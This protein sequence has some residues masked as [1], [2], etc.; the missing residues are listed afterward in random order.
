MTPMPGVLEAAP[1]LIVESDD[2]TRTML[3]TILADAGFEVL[4]TADGLEA[5]AAIKLL[6]SQQPGVIVVSASLAVMDA[7]AFLRA[8]RQQPGP[9]APAIVLTENDPGSYTAPTGPVAAVLPKPV[10]FDELLA[11]VRR[12]TRPRDGVMENGGVAG[13]NGAGA[14][15]S[16][17]RGSAGPS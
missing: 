16:A 12:Y 15:D 17:G 14:A 6:E 5:L 4:P 2:G 11:V 9:H 13:E 7:S 1:V 8:Y 3:S 10:A